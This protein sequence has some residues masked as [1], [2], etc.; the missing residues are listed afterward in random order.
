MSSRGR[1]VV[2]VSEVGHMRRISRIRSSDRTSPDFPFS[3]HERSRNQP[4]PVMLA[5]FDPLV[6]GNLRR[7]EFDF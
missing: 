3:V 6:V 1:A 7:I 4:L 2:R 5:L